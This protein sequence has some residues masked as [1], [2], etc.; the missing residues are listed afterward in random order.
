MGLPP[1]KSNKPAREQSTPTTTLTTN[2]A[3]A[4]S[5]LTSLGGIIGYTRT[6]SIPSIGAGIAVGALYLYSYLRLRAGEPLGEEIGLFAS[7]VLGGS[8]VPRVIKTG[9]K[10]VVPLMLGV[11]AIY[12]I[13]VFGKRIWSRS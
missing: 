9:G 3:L 6:G 12:G 11:F 1:H 13:G 10:K 2:S 7:V 8:S 4:L 5:L